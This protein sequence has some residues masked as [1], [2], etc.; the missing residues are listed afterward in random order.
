MTRGKSEFCLFISAAHVKLSMIKFIC[1]NMWYQSIPLCLRT[2]DMG[3]YIVSIFYFVK[4]VC[5]E[6]ILTMRRC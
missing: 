5:C 1:S 3:I 4:L 6:F 2:V